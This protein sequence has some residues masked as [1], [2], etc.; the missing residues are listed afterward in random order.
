MEME[1]I[2]Q[3]FDYFHKE[4]VIKSAAQVEASIPHLKLEEI[5]VRNCKLLLDRAALLRELP[6]AGVVAEI[7]VDSGNF[8]EQILAA[9]QPATLHL[10]DT[11]GSDRYHSGL[12]DNIQQKF[13]DRIA[14]GTLEIHRKL[15]IE[16]AADFADGTFD[17]IYIDTNHMYETTRDELLAYEPKMKPGGIIAGHDYSMGNWVDHLRYGVVEAVHEF[18]IKRGWE[19]IFLTI[20]QTEKQSFAIRKI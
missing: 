10:V 14:A 11:W 9:T 8:S 7:G 6:K 15:S 20:D 13:A 16:G 17:F 19:M 1:Q 12:M 18:C 4:V 2:Q 3:L 5:H